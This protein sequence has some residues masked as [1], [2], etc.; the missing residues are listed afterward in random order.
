MKTKNTNKMYPI[1]SIELLNFKENL[2][3]QEFEK[4]ISIWLKLERIDM[5]NFH[6]SYPI[7]WTGEDK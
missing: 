1:T 2:I 3:Y 6:L 4:M 7:N 5:N